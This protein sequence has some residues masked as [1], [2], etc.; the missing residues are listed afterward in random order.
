MQLIRRDG[1]RGLR[2]PVEDSLQLGG[3]FVIGPSGTLEYAYRSEG[4]EDRPSVEELLAAL[5]NKN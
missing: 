2:R 5:P 1:V 4:P 3:D